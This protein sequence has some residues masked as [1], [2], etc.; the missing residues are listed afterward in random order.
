MRK[1]IFALPVIRESEYQA[2]RRAVG[3]NL[4]DTYDEWRKSFTDDVEEA[5]QQGHTLVEIEVKYDE[6]MAFCS[7]T[8]QNPNAKILLDFAEQKIPRKQ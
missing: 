8:R 1:T 7:A 4:A 6:F 2:F 5:R 3:T